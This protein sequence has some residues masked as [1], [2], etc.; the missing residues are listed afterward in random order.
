MEFLRLISL[1]KSRDNSLIT[2]LFNGMNIIIKI[3][4][5][6]GII[7]EEYDFRNEKDD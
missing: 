3:F 1:N 7:L 2:I 4:G 5:N 6:R